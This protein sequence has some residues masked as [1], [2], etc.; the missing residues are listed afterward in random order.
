MNIGQGENSTRYT[1]YL[2]NI[3]GIE[4]IITELNE[5]FE[6]EYVKKEVEQQYL[7]HKNMHGM[8][9]KNM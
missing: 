3:E 1:R 4:S 8:S 9:V 7:D 5:M 2:M 6:I